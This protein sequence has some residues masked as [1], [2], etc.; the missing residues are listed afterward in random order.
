MHPLLLFGAR[1]AQDDKKPH[2]NISA[3]ILAVMHT[4]T[5]PRSKSEVLN[6]IEEHHQK[7]ERDVLP[8]AKQSEAAPRRELL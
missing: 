6:R 1:I 5:L 3:F 2:T 8:A 7:R 4:Q